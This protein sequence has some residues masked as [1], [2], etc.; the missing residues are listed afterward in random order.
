MRYYRVTV[1]FRTETFQFTTACKDIT[2]IT[3]EKIYDATC[4]H[5]KTTGIGRPEIA[6]QTTAL[7]PTSYGL[8]KLPKV[9]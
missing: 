4:K 2:E 7:S 3:A 9:V 1:N 6:Y 8:C 5:Y